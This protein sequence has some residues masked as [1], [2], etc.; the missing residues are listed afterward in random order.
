MLQ[1]RRLKSPNK[2]VRM[3]QKTPIT[4][5]VKIQR[6][7]KD[8]KAGAVAIYATQN[9]RVS[10]KA[11]LSVY[12]DLKRLTKGMGLAWLKPR[13]IKTTTT[14]GGKRM[15]KGKGI[16]ITY[17]RALPVKA[18]QLV[19]ELGYITQLSGRAL[20]MRTLLRPCFNKLSF[21]VKVVHVLRQSSCLTQ[22]A[23]LVVSKFK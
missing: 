2:Q 23:A 14:K 18:G 20:D 1:T 7:G 19:F 4:S 12:T 16:P 8:T 11:L 22:D 15:G 21:K 3:S 17:N 6:L 9:A 13:Q 10:E 5:S